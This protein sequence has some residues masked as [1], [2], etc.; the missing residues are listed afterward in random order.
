MLPERD[1]AIIWIMRTI[2]KILKS[3]GT[4]GGLLVSF[5]CDPEDFVGFPGGD[6]RDG[7]SGV[8][9]HGRNGDGESC[10]GGPVYVVFD[11]LEVPFFITSCRPKGNRYIVHL[12]D[13]LN[14]RDAE[15]MVGREILADVEEEAGDT[16]DLVGWK[17]FDCSAAATFNHSA[18]PL[19]IGTVTGEEPIPGNHCIYVKTNILSASR[20]KGCGSAEEAGP[21]EILIPLHPDFIVSADPSAREL[22]LDLPSGLY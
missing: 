11:G 1:R 15:E 6:G 3:N 18:A 10:G 21:R 8:L 17:V 16:L 9:S 19:E 22:L 20:V 12:N 7:E 14:L 13:V 2:G 4:D 5:S